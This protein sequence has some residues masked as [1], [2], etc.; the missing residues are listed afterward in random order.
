[1]SDHPN[2]KYENECIIC[3]ENLENSYVS[4]CNNC[5]LYP[6]RKIL[7]GYIT[8]AFV[9]KGDIKKALWNMQKYVDNK[10][11]EWFAYYMQK[12]VNDSF[13]KIKFDIISP[14]PV[15]NHKQTTAKNL[16]TKSIGNRMCINVNVDLISCLQSKETKKAESK[17]ARF[18]NAKVYYS[19]NNTSVVQGKAILLVDD[20]VE[21]GATNLG[22]RELIIEHGASEVYIVS[23]LC[24]PPRSTIGRWREK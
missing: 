12:V 17:K 18:E 6:S 8:S 15:P 16:L 14:I 13:N 3:R 21:T 19:I 24:N 9:N 4:V 10:T 23:A 2:N 7:E 5:I 11:I 22:I 1:M 20:I